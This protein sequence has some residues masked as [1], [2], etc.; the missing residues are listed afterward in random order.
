MH[1]PRNHWWLLLTPVLVVLAFSA[2]GCGGSEHDMMV[3]KF[4]QS[5]R[6]GDVATLGNIATVS[7]DPNKDGRAENVSFVSQTPEQTRVLKLQELDKVYKEAQAA[8]AD[9]SKRMKEYQDKNADA[10]GRVLKVEAAGKGK[11]AGGDLAVQAAWTKWREDSKV[12]QKAMAEARMALQ[13]ER[14]VADLSAPDLDAATFAEVTE[15]TTDVTYT[16]NVRTPDNQTAKK[17]LVLTLQRVVLK[18]TAGKVTEGKWMITGLKEAGAA[19]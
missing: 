13:A 7:F 17:T 18:D 16:A 14:R 19:Q 1:R 15:A 5:A 9:F 8:E 4:F 12:V 3:R 2:A 6:S 10:I 11:P